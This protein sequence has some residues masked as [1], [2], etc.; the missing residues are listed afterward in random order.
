MGKGRVPAAGTDKKCS[1]GAKADSR[2]TCT[3][4]SKRIS[5]KAIRSDMKQPLTAAFY[6]NG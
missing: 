1:T 2:I 3:V 4:T 6:F 5:F